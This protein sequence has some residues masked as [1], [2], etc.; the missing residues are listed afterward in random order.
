MGIAYLPL[1]PAL[2]SQLGIPVNNL[3]TMPG[4]ASALHG[5]VVRQV[6]PGSPAAS[7]G[8]RARDAITS[9][10]GTELKDE[11]S[12]AQI[13]SKRKPGDKITLSVQR[14]N[15]ATSLQVTLAESPSA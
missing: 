4:G 8:L 6:A 13:L 14:G 5:V 15:E 10:D 12:L 7:A 9:I 1:T 3:G 2:A 11:S